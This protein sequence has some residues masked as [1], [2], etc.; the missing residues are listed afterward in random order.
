MGDPP[1]NQPSPPKQLY[2]TSHTGETR[3]LEGPSYSTC[4]CRVRAAP[5]QRYALHLL[6][7]PCQIHAFRLFLQSLKMSPKVGLGTGEGTRGWDLWIISVVMVIVAGLL[8]AA[9]LTQKISKRHMG[10]DDYLILASLVSYYPSPNRCKNANAEQVSSIILSITEIEAVEHGYGRRYK[11]LTKE[12]AVSARKWFYGAQIAYKFVLTFNK[13]S[14]CHMI[15]R[16][17]NVSSHRFRRTCHAVQAFIFV[18][19]VAYIIGTFFQCTPVAAFWNKSIQHK[20]CFNQKPW[21]ISYA[22]LQILLD[23]VLLALPVRQ[24]LKLQMSRLERFGLI[25]V[26]CTGLFVTFTSIYRATTLAGSAANPDPTCKHFGG[27]DQ[28]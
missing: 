1:T 27:C 25:L 24:V 22:A 26:F 13:M 21:W 15:Y 3:P 10:L 7:F 20:W 4:R 6:C 12:Q 11:E 28:I 23:F 19:G 17:F 8:V 16:I 14:I 9:R 18:S 5:E 2:V